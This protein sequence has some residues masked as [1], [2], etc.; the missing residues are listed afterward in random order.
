MPHWKELRSYVAVVASGSLS[1]TARELQLP[2][3]TLSR[4]L[5][6]L[7]AD[8]GHLLLKRESNRLIPTEA[9]RA[10][11]HVGTRILQLADEGL[12]ELD[13]LSEVAQGELA[14]YVDN[15]L[16]RGWLGGVIAEFMRLYP[17]VSVTLRTYLGQDAERWRDTVFL[18]M[19]EL[20][21]HPLR[22][23]CL[24]LLS[25]GVYASQEYLQRHGQPQHPRDL[26]THQ[27][28]HLL[29]SASDT[30]VMESADGAQV[31]VALPPSR[32]QSDQLV[33][34]AD[35]ICA[36]QGLGIIPNWQ[37]QLRL[38]AHPGCFQRCLEDWEPPAMPIWLA[39]PHGKL[40]RKHQAFL[41]HLRR[42]LPDAWSATG[43]A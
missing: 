39:Y 42:H 32:M 35:A 31:P 26:Q 36:G 15:G 40:A 20:P 24:S 23:E 8:V 10:F 22:Q 13:R 9:G 30:L 4:H 28:I 6:K 7:E 11:Y 14:L 21:P 18:W 19:G 37:A 25:Q 1:A 5:K 27:W 38:R 33:L 34:H 43:A 3:S 2:K 12:D 29:G 16:L 17:E 41:T